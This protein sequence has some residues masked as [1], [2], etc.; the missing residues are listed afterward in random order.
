MVQGGQGRAGASGTHFSDHTCSWRQ[1]RNVSSV[2][3]DC[4]AGRDDDVGRLTHIV[5]SSGCQLRTMNDE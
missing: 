5:L 2:M 4:R 3:S 1:G